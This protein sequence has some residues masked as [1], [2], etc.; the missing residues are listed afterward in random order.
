MVDAMNTHNPALI[1]LKEMGYELGI[2][3]PEFDEEVEVPQT[4]VG[5]WW[6]K[7]H[8][9]EFVA[10]DPLS[11]LGIISI[12]EHRGDNWINENDVD[13]SDQLLSETYGDE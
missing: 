11:L 4:E 3:P 10:G 8:L 9:H 5:H 7:K 1:T 6:A 2:Y 13:I 12:W